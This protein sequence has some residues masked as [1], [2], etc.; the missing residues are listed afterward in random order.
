MLQSQRLPPGEKKTKDSTCDFEADNTSLFFTIPLSCSI[1]VNNCPRLNSDSTS[2]ETDN[3][4]DGINEIHLIEG[5]NT[6]NS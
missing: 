5:D 6:L 4:Q 3:I 2:S 1:V